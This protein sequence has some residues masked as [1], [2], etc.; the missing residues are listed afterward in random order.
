MGALYGADV[1]WSL[2]LLLRL[3]FS[4]L[5]IQAMGTEEWTGALR[6]DVGMGREEVRH[7]AERCVGGGC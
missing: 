2:L 1:G 7:E 5:C 6:S 3:V 4:W